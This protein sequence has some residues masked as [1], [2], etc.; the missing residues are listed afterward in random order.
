MINEPDP[1]ITARDARKLPE[2]EKILKQFCSLESC[3]ANSPAYL[4]GY[5]R[6]KGEKH[7]L[8]VQKK[9]GECDYVADTLEDIEWHEEQTHHD[10]DHFK[11]LKVQAPVTELK[12]N[13]TNCGGPHVDR[14]E[15]RKRN[16]KTHLCEYCKKEFEGPRGVGV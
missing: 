7:P 10:G 14:G 13:C 4:K 16:H 1:K 9:C 6:I 12:I 8:K 15:F 3:N 5:E 2:T 11:D